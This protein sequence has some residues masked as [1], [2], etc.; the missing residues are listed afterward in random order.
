[1]ETQ[2]LPLPRSQAKQHR[3]FF[4][5][6]PGE[7]AQVSAAGVLDGLRMTYGCRGRATPS[8]RLHV[9]LLGL[10]P[11]WQ[12]PAHLVAQATQA[13]SRIAHPPFEI[14]FD[15]VAPFGRARS[16]PL[17]LYGD[18]AG[19]AVSLAQRLSVALAGPNIAPI[20]F[21]PHMTLLYDQQG[22]PDIAV[23]PVHWTVREFVLIDSLRGEGR[24]EIL[25]RW[26]LS[27]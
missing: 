27:G 26:P 3:L 11:Y 5:L 18:G 2:Q 21:A 14:A 12:R 10:G 16:L 13:A 23:K 9:S 19:G 17:V 6:L 24:H 7:E 1:M 25:G 4:A 15:R 20:V 22:V 8:H